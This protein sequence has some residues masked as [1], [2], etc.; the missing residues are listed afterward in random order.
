MNAGF[1]KRLASFIIDFTIIFAIVFTS[2]RIIGAPILQNRIDDYPDH[3][4]IYNQAMN[5]YLANLDEIQ[6]RLDRGI[7]TESQAEIE[8]AELEE[9]FN[10]NYYEVSQTVYSYWIYSFVYF[11]VLLTLVNYLYVLGFKGRTFGRKLMKL[12]LSG[13]VTWWS[14]FIREV[15]W[16]SFF[17]IFT[18]SFGLAIDFGLI[19][20]TK[21]RKTIRDYVSGTRVI[22]DDVVYPF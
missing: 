8:R 7:Y 21:N 14:L 11:A 13:R 16:K 3:V 22:L 12:R 6:A 2:F 19:A 18:F 5:D 9:S 1:F 10:E 4:V 17:W 15:L 20:F